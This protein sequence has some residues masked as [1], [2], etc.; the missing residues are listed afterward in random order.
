MPLSQDGRMF[1]EYL[2]YAAALG[3]LALVYLLHRR[4]RARRG[5]YYDAV[6]TAGRT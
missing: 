3:G 5:R 4:A 2:N 6:L 1:W